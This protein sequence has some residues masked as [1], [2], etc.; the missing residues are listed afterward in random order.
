MCQLPNP[1][2]LSPKK[3]Q[4]QYLLNLLSQSGMDGRALHMK[5]RNCFLVRA[6]FKG[7]NLLSDSKLFFLIVATLYCREVSLKGIHILFR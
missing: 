3:I 1:D 5:K 4:L 6:S 7:K 2:F